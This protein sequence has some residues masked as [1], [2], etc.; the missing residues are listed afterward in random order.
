MFCTRC[1]K[2]LKDEDRFCAACGHPTR[3]ENVAFRAGTPARL[4]R[5]MEDKKIAGVCAGVARYFQA[6]VT[7]VRLI[8]LVLAFATGVGFIAYVIAWI[9]MPREPQ[10]LLQPAQQS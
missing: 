2:E 6:D 8:W 9:V 7:L 4:T 5:S 1:G 10:G 3:P